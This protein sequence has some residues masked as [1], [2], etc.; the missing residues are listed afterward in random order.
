[1]LRV[2]LSPEVLTAHVG[3]PAVFRCALSGRPAAEVRWAKDGTP[4]VIDRARIQLLDE[5]QALRIGSVDTRDGGMYQCAAS[6]AHESAQA[7][8]QLILG[9]TVPVLLDSFGDSSVRAGD[10]VH[11]KCEATAS[12]AP[13]ITWTLDGA[14]VPPVRSGRVDLSEA[15]R[16]EGHLVSYVN[17]SRVKME[18]GGLWQCTAS[19]SAGSV[20]A[21]ARVGVYGPPAVR[22]FAGNRTA[23]ATE[24]LSLHCRLL[25]YPIDS[26]HWEKDGR[27]LPFHHRQKVFPNGTLLVLATSVQD[28]GEYACIAANTQ[29]QTARAKLFVSVKVPP[30]IERFAF[31]ENLHQG[32]RTR[33]Y[34]NIARGDPPV[35][36]SWLRDGKPLKSG[37]DLEVRV[38]DA[39]SVALA[40]EALSPSHNGNY[41][42]LASNAAA[43]VNYTAPLRVH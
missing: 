40:I 29:G 1:P 39:F 34:C 16:G 14:P 13:K 3:H 32:M 35:S 19:N 18:D 24:T 38:L 5:R 20:T 25:S 23:V 26:V 6:N 31:D 41:T 10:T 28:A 43:S 2:S 4:L 37:P 9:D 15:T 12:P 7:T 33:V 42:C 36:I 22:P 8:A 21:S 30:L 11:L 27:R 17:I